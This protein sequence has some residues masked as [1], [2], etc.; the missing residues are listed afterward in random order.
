MTGF[1][2]VEDYMQNAESNRNSAVLRT[3]LEEEPG[4]KELPD[5][6]D[7]N[8]GDVLVLDSQKKPSWGSG[9]GG[10]GG[11]H[12][13][14]ITVTDDGSTKQYSLNCTY[15]ELTAEVESGILPVFVLTQEVGGGEMTLYMPMTGSMTGEIEGQ[16]TYVCVI[17][18]EYVLELREASFM[19]DSADGTLVYVLLK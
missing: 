4:M 16:P 3:L 2:S 11:V 13:R 5:T 12:Y 10:T 6:E 9:G 19:A 8:I 18:S 14:E 17:R 7:A 1:D 15:N